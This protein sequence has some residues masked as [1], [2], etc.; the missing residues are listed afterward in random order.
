[1]GSEG[2]YC[3]TVS[4]LSII[5][6]YLSLH[7]SLSPT[8]SLSLSLPLPPSLPPSASFPPSLSHLAPICGTMV[9]AVVWHRMMHFGCQT[10]RAKR[11]RI[12]VVGSCAFGLAVPHVPCAVDC[13]PC[14]L[15]IALTGTRTGTVFI[16]GFVQK[17]TLQSN[18][19]YCIHFSEGRGLVAPME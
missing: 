15:F 1:M 2:C 12:G 9:E 8:H 13:L 3:V 16:S 18:S 6:L 7:F 4:S 5:Y 17:K 14:S 11:A 19:S 10:C